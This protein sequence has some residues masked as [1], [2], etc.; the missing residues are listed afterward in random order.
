MRRWNSFTPTLT[1]S[2]NHS[3]GGGYFLYFS[4][5]NETRGIVIDPGYDFLE[6]LLSAGYRIGDINAVLISHAHP[7]HTDSLP[8]ILSLFHEANNR[9]GEYFH[10][11]VSNKHENFNKKHLKLILS[12]GVFDQYYKGFIKPSYESLEDVIVVKPKCASNPEVCYTDSF[13]Y[14]DKTYSISIQ[15][16][17]TRHGD[18]MKWESLGFIIKIEEQGKQNGFVRKI[19]YTSDARWS[20][21]FSN[22]FIECN[23]VCAHFGSIIDILGGKNF[24]C[25]CRN[26]VPKNN[27]GN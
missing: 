13:T 2:I 8:S 6:N 4:C 14:D 20:D 1:S 27:M 24:S 21:E 10:N 25:L 22:H 11:H 26:Y 15:A 16:F 5:N 9:L 3:K 7:D 19:G 12:Q 18:L 17:P 23:T